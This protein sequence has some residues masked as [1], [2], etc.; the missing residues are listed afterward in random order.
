MLPSAALTVVTLVVLALMLTAT[1]AYLRR[2]GLT[3]HLRMVQKVDEGDE[4]MRQVLADIDLFES[5]YIDTFRSDS[6]VT[7]P[8]LFG[9]KARVTDNL[10]TALRRLANDSHAEQSL[11]TKMQSVEDGMGD[12]LCDVN[13]RRGEGFWIGPMDSYFY[14]KA[15]RGKL[16]VFGLQRSNTV[17]QEQH[18]RMAL[19]CMKSCNFELTRSAVA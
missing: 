5:A 17:T 14:R 11:L 15:Q 4:I 8:E 19:P 10:H 2:R 18:D 6:R 1:R 9:I 3:R 16:D 13:S 7:T 12:K